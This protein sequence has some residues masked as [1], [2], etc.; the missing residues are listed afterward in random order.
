MF[1]VHR[2]LH[3]VLFHVHMGTTVISVFNLLPLS[4]VQPSINLCSCLCFV[5]QSK[6][7]KE[8]GTVS[9]MRRLT[10]IKRSKSP[11]PSSYSMD[12]PVFEDSTM[13]AAHPVHVR[14][15]ICLLG[16]VLHARVLYILLSSPLLDRFRRVELLCHGQTLIEVK[17]ENY[18][19]HLG[20]DASEIQE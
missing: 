18:S 16:K 9:L 13:S 3:F 14:Y 20:Y 2:S 1:C 15:Y 12:N 10:S 7:R 6:E 11:P 5:K 8:K 4:R 19:P 17:G